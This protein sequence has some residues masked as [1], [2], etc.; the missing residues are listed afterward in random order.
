[1]RRHTQEKPY[2]CDF[3]G[4]NKAFAIAGALTIHKRI[5][6][7]SKPFKCTYCDRAFSESSNLSKHLRTHTGARPYPCTE[8]GCNKSFARP[9]QLAR[10]MNVHKRKAAENAAKAAVVVAG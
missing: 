4:C 8:P 9:D 6:N 3:P 10:H 7:G 2:V 5:H 1:M